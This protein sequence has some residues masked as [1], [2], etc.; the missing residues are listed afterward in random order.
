MSRKRF[1][2]KLKER[3][4]APDKMKE[5]MQLAEDAKSKLKADMYVRKARNVAMRHKIRWPRGLKR[6]FCKHCYSYL[7]PGKNLRVRTH[8]GKV[9]YHCMD[10]KK[11]MRFPYTREKKLKK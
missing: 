7:R 4:Q 9:V 2:K 6:R 5:L 3:K 1:L 10:C 11:Y 8:E